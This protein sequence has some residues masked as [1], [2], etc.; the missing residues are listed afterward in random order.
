MKKI[1]I[2]LLSLL[3]ININAHSQLLKKLS[4]KIKDKATQ[5][6]DQKTDQTID[7]G[8]DKTEAGINNTG[9]TGT[10]ITPAT[11]TSTTGQPPVNPSIKDTTPTPA[12]FKAYQNY[13]F[14]PGEKFYLKI[15]FQMIK[16]ASLQRIGNCKTGRLL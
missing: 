1:F 12:V 11:N 8:L 6:A 14:I 16:T 15:I 2:A 13:D 5:R 9:K 7:K 10:A 4:N 3:L